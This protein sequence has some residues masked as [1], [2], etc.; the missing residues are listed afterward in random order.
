MAPVYY[1][2][3]IDSQDAVSVTVGSGVD[4]SAIDIGLVRNNTFSVQVRVVGAFPTNPAPAV[5]FTALRQGRGAPDLIASD[6][7]PSQHRAGQL[8]VNSEIV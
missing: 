6:D 1:P 5:V 3:V 2:G 8:R 7:R 4:T